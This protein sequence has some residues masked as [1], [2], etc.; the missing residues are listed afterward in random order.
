MVK[1]TALYGYT[2][3]HRI[4]PKKASGGEGLPPEVGVKILNAYN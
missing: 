3:F 2:S 1:Y 4:T